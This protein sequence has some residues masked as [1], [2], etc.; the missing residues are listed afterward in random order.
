LNAIGISADRIRW[1]QC[2]ELVNKKMG[3][4][5]GALFI[6][7]NFDPKSKETALEMIHN[8]R[9]AFNELLNLNDWMDSETREVNHGFIGLINTNTQM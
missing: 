5:V 2:V 4:A 9:E 7:D 6:R 3:M 1:N 8:I